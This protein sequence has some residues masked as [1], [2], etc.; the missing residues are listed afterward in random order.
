MNEIA[1]VNESFDVAFRL[2]K[3]EMRSLKTLLLEKVITDLRNELNKESL[4][5]ILIDKA[6]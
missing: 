6:E 3:E 4:T 2:I 1:K 5:K